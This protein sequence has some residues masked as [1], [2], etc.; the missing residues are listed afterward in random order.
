MRPNPRLQRTAL[1]SPLS[2]QPLGGES[3]T[4]TRAPLV[5]FCLLVSL[6]VFAQPSPTASPTPTAARDIT[7]T[8]RPS[9]L[10]LR[11]TSD[12]RLVEGCRQRLQGV[13]ALDVPPESFLAG[14]AKSTGS[15]VAWVEARGSI[16]QDVKVQMYRLYVCS[17]DQYEAI[18]VA[19]PTPTPVQK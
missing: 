16:G 5:V 10:H 6:R 3:A 19:T 11:I 2:R 14:F 7:Q 13:L 17:K 9:P 18:P 4:R 8:P 15:N 1:R 12:S